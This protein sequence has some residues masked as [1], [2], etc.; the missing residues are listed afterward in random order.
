MFECS[1]RPLL[2]YHGG[3][4]MIN[5]AREPLLGLNGVQRT[6]NLPTLSPAQRDALDLIESVARENQ[7][8]LSA[9]PGDFLFINNHGILHSR[10]HFT[11]APGR[12]RYLAR[13]WLKSPL[14]AWKL[15]RALEEGNGRI[16][17]ECE[18]GERWNVVDVPKV[19]FRLSERLT[20]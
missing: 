4:V 6:P 3:H 9:E 5:F 18:L 15:P 7:L 12:M 8:T 13:L 2:F 20:S 10:E 17:G 16:Y 14:L 11:D 1:T 19:R